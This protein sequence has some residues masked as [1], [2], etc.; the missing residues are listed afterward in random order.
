MGGYGSGHR[1]TRKS[2]VEECRAVDIAVLP[3]SE[4]AEQ[5]T[6]PRVLTWR[7]YKDEVT[8]SIG[9]R[10][11]PQGSGS[12]ILRFSYS[13]TG[14]GNEI[15]IEEPVP[16]VTTQPY[17][18]GVRVSSSVPLQGITGNVSDGFEKSTFHRVAGTSAA[19]SVTT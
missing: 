1:I 12:A 8:A 19:G 14:D 2:T 18:G 9:Y 15:R 10:C 6:W 13:V 16:V 4:F 11:E 3:V 5:S 7:N 17:F